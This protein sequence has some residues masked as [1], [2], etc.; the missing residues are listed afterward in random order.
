MR[1]GHG[2]L[3]LPQDTGLTAVVR[4]IS[5][6]PGTGAIIIEGELSTDVVSRGVVLIDRELSAEAEAH[7]WEVTEGHSREEE[8][9]LVRA[10]RS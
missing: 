1:R 2:A 5:L 8:L 7:G 6:V 3:A 9:G 4:K 10:K